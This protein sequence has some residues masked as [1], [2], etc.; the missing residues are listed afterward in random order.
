MPAGVL[1]SSKDTAGRARARRVEIAMT[2][3]RNCR[4]DTAGTMQC[5]V[6]MVQAHSPVCVTRSAC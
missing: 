5:V 1:D 6:Q 2:L 4:V 3:A